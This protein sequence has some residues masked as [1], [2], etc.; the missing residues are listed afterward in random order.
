M[1]QE[2]IQKTKK[3]DFVFYKLQRPKIFKVV[4]DGPTKKIFKKYE[5][6]RYF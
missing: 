6:I 1:K 4:R 3:G 2:I 5:F